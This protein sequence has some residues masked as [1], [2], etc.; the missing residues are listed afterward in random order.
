MDNRP[1]YRLPGD[2]T[3]PN[4]ELLN[5]ARMGDAEAQYQVGWHYERDGG[6]AR[7]NPY[8]LAA[9]CNGQPGN[10]APAAQTHRTADDAATFKQMRV[11]E[12][13]RRPISYIPPELHKQLPEL[14]AT[15]K[16]LPPEQILAAIDQYIP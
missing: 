15:P 7:S 12:I 16:T 5:P 9:I 10:Y 6:F 3:F 13:T 14:E 2:D 1:D 11:E 4:R 8:Y